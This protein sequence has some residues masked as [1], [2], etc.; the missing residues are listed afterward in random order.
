MRDFSGRQAPQGEKYEGHVQRVAARFITGND[1]DIVGAVGVSPAESRGLALQSK[2]DKMSN[3][4]KKRGI[5]GG[6]ADLGELDGRD[7]EVSLDT[8]SS[9][10][11]NEGSG[12]KSG[13]HRIDTC[14]A[15][16]TRERGRDETFCLKAQYVEG[17]EI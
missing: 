16:R 6:I 15:L 10:S 7:L 1:G 3:R 9:E 17:M 11:E 4:R 12:R 8:E 13:I 14:E 5:L 2:R